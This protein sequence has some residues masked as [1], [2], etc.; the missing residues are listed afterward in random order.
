MTR[1][2]NITTVSRPSHHH[3]TPTEQRTMP[4]RTPNCGH[5][6]R[7]GGL[8]EVWTRE[9]SGR[10]QHMTP[11]NFRCLL[12]PQPHVLSMLLMPSLQYTLLHS[13]PTVI[14]VMAVAYGWSTEIGE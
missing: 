3:T 2:G 4:P 8:R 9:V 5:L 14:S 13:K 7:D 1:S 6:E 11:V 10:L 12:P